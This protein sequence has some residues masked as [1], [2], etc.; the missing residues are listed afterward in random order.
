MEIDMRGLT[1]S[2]IE[3]LQ[4]YISKY[5]EVSGTIPPNPTNLDT[6][7]KNIEVELIQLKEYCRD[8]EKIRMNH[9]VVE[10]VML[11]N[12]RKMM[13]NYNFCVTESQYLSNRSKNIAWW[14][15]GISIMINIIG[16]A[17]FWLWR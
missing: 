17:I 10:T 13:D 7:L 5:K 6:D 3:M 14:L 9:Q 8:F 1:S 15:A 2:Q 12:L 11:S 16:M 4:K